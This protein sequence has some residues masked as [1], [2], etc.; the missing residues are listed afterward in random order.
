[1]KQATYLNTTSSTHDSE[2]V[3][4]CQDEVNSRTALDAKWRDNWGL[5]KT[6]PI[7]VATDEGWQSKINDGR[8]FEL[9]ETVASYI[10]NALFFSD[11]WVGLEST[12]PDLGE[13]LPL[14]NTYFVD[15]L[16]SS[17]FKREFRVFLSQYLLTGFSCMLPLWDSEKGVLCFETL[18]N[19]DTFIET[20]CRY[21]ESTS[22]TF[23]RV[24]LNY[25][26]FI[27]WVE[28]GLL[29]IDGD[30]ESAFEKYAQAHDERK[31]ELSGLSQ[32]TPVIDKSTVLVYEYYC[33]IEKKIYRYIEEDCVCEEDGWDECPWLVG[34]L[35]ET[36]DE[37]YGLSLLD[38][39]IGLVIANNILHNQ[40]LDNIALNI[41]NMWQI[42]DDGIV[43]PN[44]VKSEPGKII[45]VGRPDTIT[46]LQPSTNS[47][48][49]SFQEQ[50]IL[51]SKIDRNTGTGAM[52]SANSY[53]TGERVTA[54]EIES[55]KDAGG[56][57]LTDIFEHL[58]ATF[59]VPLL[60]RSLK[61]LRDNIKKPKVVKLAS[62][63]ADV[64]D[65]FKVLPEDF[66][67]DFTVKVT[68]TQSVINRDKNISLITEYIT[69]VSSVPQ[70]AER[71]DWDTLFL[72]MTTKFGFDDPQRYIV[73]QQPEEPAP[74][75]PQSPLQQMSAQ[76]QAIGG[77]PAQ[78]GLQEA[79]LK[80]QA[81]DIAASF[82][83]R[84][85]DDIQNMSEEE[86]LLSTAYLST[87]PQV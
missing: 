60:K 74:Q 15:A 28:D 65:Y 10:R 11:R 67:H 17:N 44:E 83:G 63:R 59:I 5:Y 69:V 13:I 4:R 40:R 82:A 71:V 18:N 12:E 31:G 35:F 52:V 33:P 37:A 16:N 57:R 72:D 58:E 47:F 36:P 76:A 79:I 61:I 78:A 86:K 68:G 48:G 1:M 53:R 14:V 77:D 56:N 20:G 66:K 45:I 25:A 3:S 51:D 22:Y 81:P 32:T 87:P 39:S 7:T 80:G 6:Q 55:V 8:V 50:Q 23:R 34:I 62:N 21:E 49:V 41:N 2:I 84:S 64:Y 38:S 73:K 26:Q 42:I 24:E 19:Y 43:N 85:P 46:P 9:V 29:E 30:E 27:D 75:T 70:F 54:A